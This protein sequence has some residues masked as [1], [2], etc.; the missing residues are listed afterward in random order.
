MAPWKFTKAISEG[1]TIDVY[2]HGDM[3]RDFTY[4]DDIVEGVYLTLRKQYSD[5][6]NENFRILNIGR[7]E[8][9][10][11]MEFIKEIEKHIGKEARINMMPIQPGDVQKTWA[12]TSILESYINFIPTTSITVGTSHFTHWFSQ[13]F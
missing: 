2:N 12:K 13:R 6:K 8:P 10:N 7:N 4:I 9:V 11:L 5:L 3:E 1:K